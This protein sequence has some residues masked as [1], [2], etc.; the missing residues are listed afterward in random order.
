MSRLGPW[1]RIALVCAAGLFALTI[2]R[3]QQS[4]GPAGLDTAAMDLSVRPGDDFWAFATGGRA[5]ST[6]I[7]GDRGHDDA[8][9]LAAEQAQAQVAGIVQRA[10]QTPAPAGSDLRLVGDYYAA[11]MDEDGIEARG[12]HPLD[13]RR[14]A[15]GLISDRH[16]LARYIG[17][18]LRTDVD[19]LNTPQVVTDNLFGLW[20]APDLD[21]PQRYVPYLLQG[22]LGMP[23]RS[24]YVDPS[25]A[26]AAVRAQYADHV[27]ALL[28]L[29]GATLPAVRAQRVTALEQRI[30]AA[31]A[32]RDATGDARR[33]DNHWRRGD[34][35]RLAPGVDWTT[36]FE[37]AGLP[38]AQRDVIVWQPEAIRGIAA[39]VG[40]EPLATWK[41]YLWVHAIEHR[42][43]LLPKA[44]V[45]EYSAF[46]GTL[47]GAVPQPRARWKR[48]IAATNAAL[49]D[50]VGRLY[51][52][53][54]FP[55]EEK[56]GVEAMVRHVREALRLRIARVDWLSPEG[57]AEAQAKLAA[58]Q[59]GVGYPDQW[60]DYAGLAVSR[61]D[62]FGNAERAAYFEYRHQLAKLGHPV[63]RGEWVIAPQSATVV[64]L[65][66]MNALNL[67]AAILQLP[68]YA[69]D[70][71]AAVNYGVVG[72]MIGRE[73]SQSLDDR[74]GRFDARGQLRDWWSAADTV[75]LLDARERLAAQRSGHELADLWGLAAALDA[76]HAAVP[77]GTDRSA[78]Y[79]GDQRFF[80]AY[81]QARRTLPRDNPLRNLDAW[82]EAFDVRP[83]QPQF[84]DP[85]QRVRLW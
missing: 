35:Q 26:M 36:L 59:V 55:P 2:G 34:F 20:I 5:G 64:S 13:P 77:P 22:G 23:D 27:A 52:V 45:D 21:A 18:T 66:A 14:S 67:A 38:S 3:A 80:I 75:R 31:H 57:R 50:A 12:L 6:Q 70:R 10:A 71:D 51:V 54:Y 4:T 16:E 19:P 40:S 84:L 79:S 60:R 58:M 28:R 42:A 15:I 17:A 43:A 7:P 63:D 39:L 49:G 41:D 33:G 85:A 44:I 32:T 61:D 37:A 46:Q 73:L 78:G 76:Y 1:R 56:A 25:P 74:G 8:G 69:P 47:P 65:P 53:R 62:A 48:A 82:V 9:E 29:A 30:A 72:A 83:G 11:Y 68:F 81:A 24:D